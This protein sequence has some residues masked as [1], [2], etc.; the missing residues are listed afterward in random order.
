MRQPKTLP[1][2]SLEECQQAHKLLATHVAYMMGRKLEEGDWAEVYCRAKGIPNKGWSNLKLDI[3]YNGLGVEHKMLCYR[4]KVSLAD[5]YG[6]TFMHPSATRSIRVPSTTTEANKAMH[7]VLE[8]YANFINERREKVKEDYGG[9]E[10]D[11]RTGW[12]LWQESLRQ[13]LYFEEEMLVPNPDDYTAEWRQRSAGGTRKESTNLW[14]YEKDT[15]RKRYSVTTEAGAKIQPYFDVPSPTDPNVYLLTVIGEVIDTGLVKVWLTEAT[16]RELRRLLAA[17][18]TT[19]VSQAIIEVTSTISKMD[20]IE[21]AAAE[22]AIPII[23]TE[24][25]YQALQSVM[26][27]K[28]DEHSFQLFVQYLQH[29]DSF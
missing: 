12:L 25:A 26:P 6:Q 24:E 3:M 2:F 20:S 10:P 8:Q 7:D 14:I 15:G 28:S 27:G 17:L 29:K 23:I 21:Q 1:A 4:S 9:S 11:M 13:F 5:A 22:V 16:A 19:T 18:D